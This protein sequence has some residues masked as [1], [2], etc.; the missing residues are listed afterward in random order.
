MIATDGISD[1][2]KATPQFQRS[3]AEMMRNLNTPG[4]KEALCAH[5]AAHL[6]YTGRMGHTVRFAIMPSKL[7]YNTDT[8]RYEGHYAA[9]LPDEEPLCESD[10]L[11][12]YILGFA[13]MSVAGGVVSRKLFPSTDGGDGGDKLKLEQ[14]CGDLV[15]HFGCTIDVEQLWSWARTE[16]ESQ[17]EADPKLMEQIQERAAEIWRILGY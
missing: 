12:Q 15:A 13:C 9:V 1:E 14:V 16:V 11:E 4:F 3:F 8:R 6:V 10:K 7:V 17:L 5:E 2:Q